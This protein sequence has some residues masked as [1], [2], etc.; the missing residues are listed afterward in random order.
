MQKPWNDL[1]ICW[2]EEKRKQNR[3]KCPGF[4]LKEERSKKYLV[5]KTEEPHQPN[6]VKLVLILVM[7]SMLPNLIFTT[8]HKKF[9]ITFPNLQKNKKIHFPFN[10]YSPP[11]NYASRG[12]FGI[13]MSQS[14]K[15]FWLTFIYRF[16][17][18]SSNKS[19]GRED[20]YWVLICGL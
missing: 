5:P 10:G 15:P 17:T 13:C 19:Y 1:R 20:G 11:V 9:S 3:F 7:V 8:F 6:H 4:R 2:K 12:L 18:S 14:Y 16:Y